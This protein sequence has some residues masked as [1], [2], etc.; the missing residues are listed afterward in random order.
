MIWDIQS[1]CL[2]VTKC[3]TSETLRYSQLWDTLWMSS[4]DRL[5]MYTKILGK[6]LFRAKYV[7]IIIGQWTFVKKPLNCFHGE[8]GTCTRGKNVHGVSNTLRIFLSLYGHGLITLML[9]QRKGS[10]TKGDK[11]EEMNIKDVHML[12]VH[13]VFS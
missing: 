13:C 2:N 11:K 1:V 9:G 6:I 7:Y 12:Q 3:F 8:L 10:G 5:W 4:D